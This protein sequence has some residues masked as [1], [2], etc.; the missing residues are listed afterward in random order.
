MRRDGSS[1]GRLPVAVPAGAV[2]RGGAL[3][4][5]VLLAVL[6]QPLG[7]EQF[8]F[9]H[10]QGDMYRLVTEV[11]ESVHVNGAFS[12][13][14]DILNRIA[15]EVLEARGGRG[16]LSSTF[17]TSERAYGA[18]GSF[19]LAEDYR[20]VF[21]RDTRGAY[22][23]EPQYFM[24][25]V[26]DVP[27]FPPEDIP[28]G[29]SWTA[30]GEEVHDLRRS[31]GLAQPFRFPI[32]VNYTYLRDEEQD[33]RRLAVLR[34]RYQFFHQ[35]GLRGDARTLAPVRIAGSS[36]QLLRWDPGIGRPHSYE[37]SF[38]FLFYLSSGDLV[39]YQGTARGYLVDAPRLDRQQ[40]VDEIR[41]DLQRQ[42]VDDAT[43]SSD[44][45]GVTITLENIQFPPDSALLWDSE[46]AK[47]GRIGEILRRYP[48][49]DIAIT[50]H[51]ARVGTE[52]S[53][54]QLSEERARAVADFLLSLGVRR[55]AQVVSRGMGSRD[56][57]ADNSTEAGRR[58][59]RRVE[60]TI[61]EN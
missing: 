1:A 19:T 60:I 14:A 58:L 6:L 35:T 43:V 4:G 47:L 11:S 59:N 37:E 29:A 36:D 51:A 17:Q 5:A 46:Q 25:V 56:P 3:L 16:R 20:S 22:Q 26:R 44:E 31:F 41:E 61:L 28:V 40:M 18:G 8:G 12:H 24:P 42:G 2:H 50:G 57:L 9:Q 15:V 53:C 23:I 52:E 21:W 33:G 32:T 13:Q 39:E 34:I 54:Q 38:D 10:Q 55:P 7:A 48:E 49:R 45:M 30:E 27:L